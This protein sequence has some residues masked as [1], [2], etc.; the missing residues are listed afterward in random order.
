MGLKRIYRA[1][2]RKINAIPVRIETKKVFIAEW[3]AIIRKYPVYKDVK[4]THS[5][6]RAFNKFWKK[7]YGKKIPSMWHK[8][9]QKCSGEFCVEYMPELIYSTKIEPKMDDYLYDYALEDKSLVEILSLNSGCVV[10]KTIV[11]CSDGVFYDKGRKVISKK[12]AI[13][14]AANER[15]MIVK[16]TVG[17]SSGQGIQIIKEPTITKIASVFAESGKDF[18]IQELIIPH[19]DFAVYNPSSINTIRITTYILNGKI[20]HFPLC[21]R[22]GRSGKS[23]DNIHA[24]GLGIG[25]NDNGSLLEYAYDLGWGDSVKKLKAHPDTGVVFADQTLPCMSKIIEAAN[26][27]QGRFPHTKIIS[28]DFTVNDKNEPVLI[29]ANIRGQA[30]WFPQMI[31]GKSVFGDNT[32]EILTMIR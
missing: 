22:I 30:V 18:I 15:N 8:L 10:P 12:K 6:K 13:L 16:P 14:I 5:Q 7:N 17:S 26:E 29:E 24:G 4:W 21:F 32:A 9:Y 25:V 28:W 31:H 19:K 27:L 23:V 3:F 11:V 20:Y 1:F 2:I